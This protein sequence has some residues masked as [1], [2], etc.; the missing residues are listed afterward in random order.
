MGLTGGF[1]GFGD[2][3]L[4]DRL[5][6]RRAFEQFNQITF[7][8]WKSPMEALL[9]MKHSKEAIATPEAKDAAFSTT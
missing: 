2:S 8:R 7:S 1:Y 6:G 3:G 5:R 4:G 9:M